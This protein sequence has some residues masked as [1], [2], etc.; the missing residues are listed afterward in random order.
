MSHQNVGLV[1]VLF[2]TLSQ[3]ASALSFNFTF[4]NNMVLQQAPARASVYG[5]ATSA[6]GAVQVTVVDESTHER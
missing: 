3:G 4:G 2:C 1:L 5:V 6:E